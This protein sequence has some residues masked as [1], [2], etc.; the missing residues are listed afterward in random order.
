MRRLVRLI[1]EKSYDGGRT[2]EV[3]ED[4]DQRIYNGDSLELRHT[5][6]AWGGDL[7]ML[8]P[9]TRIQVQSRLTIEVI[10]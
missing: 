10:Q 8:Q 9:G 2:W 6:N 3:H 5:L 1:T 4:R 7:R